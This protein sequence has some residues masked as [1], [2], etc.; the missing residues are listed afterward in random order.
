MLD[1]FLTNKIP[2]TQ[3]GW[4]DEL[5]RV[6]SIFNEFDGEPFDYDQ[7]IDRF[8]TIS[9]RVPDAR[10]S[11]DY[12]DEYGA[13]G[14]YLGLMNFERSSTGGGWICRINKRAQSLLCDVL[15][16]PEAYM[17][18]QLSL[19]QY[20]NPIGFRFQANGSIVIE[21]WSLDK[22]IRQ[23]RDGIKTAPFRLLMRVLLALAEDFG[24]NEAVLTYAEIWTCLFN[25]PHAVGTF[26]PDG[27]ELASQV[28]RF[29]GSSHGTVQ[30]PANALRNLHIVTHTGLIS[31]RRPRSLVLEPDAADQ[32][33][34]LGRI[35]REVA[36]LPIH[37]PTPEASSSDDEIKDWTLEVL[38]S[39][40]WARYYSGGEIETDA[41]DTILQPI[42]TLDATLLNDPNYGPGA[43]L[44]DLVEASRIRGRRLLS[45]KASPEETQILRE[46]ANFQHRAIVNLLATRLR[47][48]GINPL[49]NIF[50][51][52]A[53][54][55]PSKKMLFEVKSCQSINMLSQV[56]KGVSQLYEYRYRHLSLRGAKPVLV[57]ETRPSNE[58]DWIVEYL[59]R[60]RGI[61]L[62]WLEGDETLA[63]PSAC[64]DCLAPIVHRLEA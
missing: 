35:A 55:M 40:E 49:S 5:I 63:A 3:A 16:D 15:P 36:Y 64:G 41:A 22:R 20:P 61:A 2:S 57:L 7:I 42:F 53:A 38:R 28:M 8:A 54:E 32:N 17:R 31:Y 21:H 52:V 56:R 46:K 10:D 59:I 19:F 9:R 60:D 39:G 12:R 30:V 33:T 18:L 11:A 37:F 4:T 34:D 62:C 50:I 14:S 43:P 58:S 13:Y 26:D 48:A 27:R 1:I 6:A 23:I 24:S 47:A 45:R 44:H 29:R 51:D 25:Q